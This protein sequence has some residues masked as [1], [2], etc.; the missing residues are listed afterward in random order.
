MH[1]HLRS[2]SKAVATAGCLAVLVTAGCGSSSNSGG[3]TS[4]GC[5]SGNKALN[6]ATEFPVSGTDATATIP[7]QNGVDLAV[8]QANLGCGFTLNIIHKNDEGASGADASIGAANV[9]ALVSD[10]SVIGIV[11]PF[12]SGVGKAEI[13]VVN[14]AG[15]PVLISPTNTNPGL[16]IEQYASANG[17]VFS[18]LHPAGKPDFY[19]RIPANDV[20]QGKADAMVAASPQVG[21]T[22]VYVID[23]NTTYGKGLS[24]YF[25]QAFQAGGGTVKGRQSITPAQVSSF[26]QLATTIKN[27]GANVV[28]YGGVTSQGG[29]ALKKDLVAAGFNGAMVGG[30]GIAEDPGWLTTAG[31]DAVNTVATIAAPDI[32]ALNNSAAQAFQTAYNAKFPGQAL[33]AYSAQ[34]Y[35]AANVIITAIKNVIAAHK[36]VT[37]LNVRDEVAKI[38]FTGVTGNISFDSNGDNKSGLFSVYAVDATGKWVFKQEITIS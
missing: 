21:G 6:L 35:D 7:A 19:F 28:F 12:N 9:H 16:T 5:P 26:P 18:V 3:T 20:A 17:I 32:T 31:A 2:L 22:A 11:G 27:S 25:T 23:D 8:S 4:N 1:K 30:D 33:T 15:G 36:A 37:R 38:N 34:S 24:D 14:E 13:P 10:P 29:G